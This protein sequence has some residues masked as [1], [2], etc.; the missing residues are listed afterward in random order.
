ME[1]E[2]RKKVFD[3]EAF[4][5]NVRREKLLVTNECSLLNPRPRGWQSRLK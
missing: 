1:E 5:R 2:E 3:D 4:E